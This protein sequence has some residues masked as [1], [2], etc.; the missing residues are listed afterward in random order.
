MIPEP[1]ENKIN[2][3]AKILTILLYAWDKSIMLSK[4][5]IILEITS[6]P[7]LKR[8]AV[9]VERGWKISPL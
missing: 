2:N 4:N 5:N 3:W 9:E 7:G 1:P 6:N 8:S